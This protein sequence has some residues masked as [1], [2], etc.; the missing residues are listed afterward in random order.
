MLRQEGFLPDIKR[1]LTEADFRRELESSNPDLIIS[2]Y[3]L[4]SY[5]GRA[6]LSLAKSIAPEIPFL[7]YSGTIGEEA[8]IDALR[9]GAID[10]VLKDKPRRLVSAIQ[11]ALDD[12]RRKKR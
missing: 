11:R 5:S 7:F 9:M 2:D 4:P 6:A 12:A 3:S 1:V 8:A 10:Y